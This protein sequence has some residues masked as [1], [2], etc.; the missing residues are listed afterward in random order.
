MGAGDAG[1]G[2]ADG[3]GGQ[4]GGGAR[5]G[6][7]RGDAEVSVAVRGDDGSEAQCAAVRRA[8][9]HSRKAR[10]AAVG[11]EG[12]GRVWGG[13]GARLRTVRVDEPAVR[14]GGV[15]VA[16]VDTMIAKLKELGA[17]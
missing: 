10:T 16:D 1:G 2:G 12:R 14:A 3:G 4:G 5:G 15:K 8:A 17:L 9:Q 13:S 6:R 11:E 7:A